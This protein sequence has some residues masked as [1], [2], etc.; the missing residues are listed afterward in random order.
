[1]R[2]FANLFLVLFLAD[3]TLSVLDELLSLLLGGT[4]L[5]GLRNLLAN[6]VILLAIPLYLSL[7][8]D[9]R[10][11]KLVFLP[12]ILFVLF[13]P[14]SIWLFPS[15]AGIKTYGLLMASIQVLLFL[16][17]LV[18]I[19]KIN[20]APITSHPSSITGIGRLLLP[21]GIFPPQ[22]FSLRNTLIFGAANLFIAPLALLLL[23]LIAANG[24]VSSKTAGFMRVGPDG[25][26]MAERIYRLDRKTVRLVGMIHI[27]EKDYYD[28]LVGSVSSG[29]TVVLAE[30]VTDEGNLLENRLEYGK[31]AGYL[32][33]TSQEGMRF[34]GRLIEPDEM[35]QL[36]TKAEAA[37][38]DI[39]VADVD[40]S[41][42]R[43]STI[44]FLNEL[45]KHLD[46]NPSM[47]EGLM[48]FNAWAEKNVTPEINETIMEDILHKRNKE[49]IRHLE[50]AISRYDTVVIP[51]GALHMAEIEESV[52]K[53]GYVLQ[54]ER[55]RLS[56]D[57]LKFFGAQG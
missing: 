45:G 2:I 38:P 23:A 12:L 55:E 28:D 30:G 51:W 48:A 34:N 54:E 21:K 7:G 15:L 27:G 49:L 24:F 19:R 4:P 5:S 26:Y 36:S 13:C 8:I 37:L 39:V 57:F 16:V 17:P 40:I 35:G 20:S 44:R 6:S 31:V 33:L 18:H 43:P 25:V 52:L 29:R 46:R 53:K 32:G 47:A 41:S 42:F 56:I 50:K 10:L 9:K 1:M 22:F 3:G 14:L 11:P